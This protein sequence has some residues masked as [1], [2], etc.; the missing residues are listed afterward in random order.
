MNFDP[1]SALHVHVR[2]GRDKASVF[3][4]GFTGLRFRGLGLGVWSSANRG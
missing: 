3:G 1:V 4:L 2:L